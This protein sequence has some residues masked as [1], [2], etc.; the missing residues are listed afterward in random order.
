MTVLDMPSALRRF[1]GVPPNAADVLAVKGEVT[2]AVCIPA[3]D[4]AAT[5]GPIVATCSRLGRAG[6][7]EEV[8]VIDD[9]STDATAARA[10]RAGAT[11]L[12][13]D[14]GPGKGEALRSAIAHTM[15]DVLVFLDGD[16]A[17]FSERFVLGLAL[18]L[19]GEARLQLV[20]AAY[21]RPLEGRPDE[22]GRVSEL[23]ARPLLERFYPDLAVVTQPLGGECAVRRSAVEAPLAD[24]YGIEIGLL[25]DVYRRFGMEAIAE[26][27]LGERIHRHR[28]LHQLRPHAR[29]ILDAVLTRACLPPSRPGR[30][31]L[32]PWRNPMIS[33]RSVTNTQG[34][35]FTEWQQENVQPAAGGPAISLNANTAATPR[36]T[37]CPERTRF[38]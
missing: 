6:V 38:S 15:A 27:D 21:R 7:V 11:V 34:E 19:L 20:K 10:R 14:G 25:I 18:P 9:H 4:E 23:V 31:D 3:R 5:I 35:F 32:A 28:P 17:N 13:N 2:I 37:L 12:A 26:A 24:G 22:G 29:A 33:T 36:P 30:T 8:V 1:V 16:V